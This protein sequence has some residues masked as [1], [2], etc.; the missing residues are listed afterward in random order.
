MKEGRVHL[1]HPVHISHIPHI[2]TV[3]IIHTAEPA[4]DG[5]IGNGSGVWVTGIRRGVEQMTVTIKR[6]GQQEE[7]FSVLFRQPQK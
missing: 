7:M 5:V 1:P 3:V 6:L 2:Q 4:A